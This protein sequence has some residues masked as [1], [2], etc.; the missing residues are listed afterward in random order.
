[1]KDVEDL[2]GRLMKEMIQEILQGEME[3]HL[4]YKKH[5]RSE[6]KNSR[7]GTREKTF[8]TDFGELPLEIP[9][10][11]ESSFK[12]I[13]VNNL[14]SLSDGLEEKIIAL[15]ARGLSTR[16]LNEHLAEIYGVKVSA[17]LVSN[18]TDKIYPKI[19]EWQNRQLDKVYPVVFFDCIHYS[20][21]HE[22]RVIKKAVYICLAIDSNGLKDILGMWIGDGAESAKYWLTVANE[23]KNRG[24][25][26]IL[27]ACMD[28]LTGLADSIRAVFPKVEIQRCIIHQVR[29]SVKHVSYKDRKQICSDLKQIYGSPT[30]QSGYQALQEFKDKWDNKYPSISKSWETNWTELSTFFA[31]PNEV[32]RLIYTTNALESLNRQ[33]RKVT[34]A[35]EISLLINH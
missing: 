23:L 30:E 28:G 13:L 20:V 32:R 35:K 21:R 10:D 14:G 12:P 3:S 25:E 31:Y 9:R 15:Y 2:M 26:D 16:D 5:E 34:K 27:I 24:L 8:K 17:E 18:V 1:M 4:G 19:Q 33:F 29:N 11:R 7:N 22:S 6:S